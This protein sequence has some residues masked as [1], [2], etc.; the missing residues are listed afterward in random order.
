MNEEQAALIEELR[1][2]GD[3]LRVS[4]GLCLAAAIGAAL[5]GVALV[6]VFILA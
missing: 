5:I 6:V 3:G 1:R 2:E 4:R